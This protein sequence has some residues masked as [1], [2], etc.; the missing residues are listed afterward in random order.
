MYKY[1][2]LWKFVTEA[3]T[4][5]V[6]IKKLFLKITQYSEE[7]T[8]ENR[9]QSSCD[10]AL[11]T[12]CWIQ[13]V[14]YTLHDFHFVKII[15]GLWGLCLSSVWDPPTTLV[16]IIVLDHSWNAYFLFCSRSICSLPDRNCS[17]LVCPHL[18]EKIHSYLLL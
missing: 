14:T 9:S 5:Y 6:S 8:Y 10:F 7:N 15:D 18:N 12:T 11:D 16:I 13:G 1:G 2:L 4:R 3:A 17:R